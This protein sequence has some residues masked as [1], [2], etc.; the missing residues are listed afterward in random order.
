MA[1][2]SVIEWISSY[3][4]MFCH[5]STFL[6]PTQKL[7]DLF[8]SRY[9]DTDFLKSFLKT[10]LREGERWFP[11]KERSTRSL[12]GSK[13]MCHVSTTCSTTICHPAPRKAS[14]RLTL[15]GP[16]RLDGGPAPP[17]HNGGRIW[18][19]QYISWT[20]IG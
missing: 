9:L 7:K 19:G 1:L 6:C 15:T 5:Y 3:A 4:I 11:L 10:S 18:K 20:L 13:I 14:S 12:T 16:A 8:S 2:K 17:G